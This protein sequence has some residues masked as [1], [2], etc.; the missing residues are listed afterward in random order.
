MTSKL[1]SVGV[2]NNMAPTLKSCGKSVIVLAAI[3]LA[4]C[5]SL[6]GHGVNDAVKQRASERWSALVRGEFTQA[7]AYSTP[8]F[9]AV[10]TAE[11]FR[12]RFG[13]AV[14]WV[15]SE[16]VKVECPETVKCDVTVR[17]DFKPVVSG[18]AGGD[19][20]THVGETW[21]LEDG[22]WWYFQSI[23]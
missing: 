17:V 15:G 6:S 9:R 8:G 5:A 12:N 22:Q 11:G 18:R 16:V 3:A 13:G 7:Y 14:K 19:I 1:M 4:G 23:K 21:L 2:T 20:S 10:V